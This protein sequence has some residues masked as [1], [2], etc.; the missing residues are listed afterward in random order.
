MAQAA[1]RVARWLADQVFEAVAN[2]GESADSE[3]D[4]GVYLQCGKVT[5]CSKKTAHVWELSDVPMPSLARQITTA[6]VVP[7]QGF[8]QPEPC[9]C[10]AACL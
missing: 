1:G 4:D 8:R 10:G 9:L 2:I 5:G 7:K 6:S 3:E